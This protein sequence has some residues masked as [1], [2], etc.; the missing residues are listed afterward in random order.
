MIRSLSF[1]VKSFMS[2]PIAKK[3]KEKKSN[4]LGQIDYDL[5]HIN[6]T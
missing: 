2:I 1:N 5:D 6:H 3:R 4:T